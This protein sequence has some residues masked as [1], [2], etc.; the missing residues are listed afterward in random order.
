ME[1]NELLCHF[2]P[3]TEGGVDRYEVTETADRREEAWLVGAAV[4]ANNIVSCAANASGNGVGG[5]GPS[6]G[7]HR[8]T[9]LTTYMHSLGV[10]VPSESGASFLFYPAPDFEGSQPSHDGYTAAGTLA[11]HK[12]PQQA[13]AGMRTLN[14][15]PN[16]NGPQP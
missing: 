9:V 1:E 3:Y 6:H 5:V 13:D 15:S 8:V 4:V 12:R 16:P 7:W 2:A 10:E 11:G 14:P